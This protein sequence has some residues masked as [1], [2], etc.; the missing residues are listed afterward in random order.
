MPSLGIIF[1]L[2]DEVG[3]TSP[4]LRKTLGRATADGRLFTAWAAVNLMIFFSL[5][6]VHGDAGDGGSA[7]TNSW[8]VVGLHV[9]LR[10]H[11]AYIAAVP[12]SA[13]RGRLFG[14]WR[15]YTVAMWRRF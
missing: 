7:E 14:N 11:L 13:T 1:S 10:S 4:D 2:G 12:A 3:E 6:A 8:E 5:C 9:R 15:R